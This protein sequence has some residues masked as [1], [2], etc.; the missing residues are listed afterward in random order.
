MP[1]LRESL[2]AINHD[3]TDLDAKWDKAV[4]HDTI[5]EPRKASHTVSSETCLGFV[6]KTPNS[7][8]SLCRILASCPM[9]LAM[10]HPGIVALSDP[11]YA[12]MY[13]L[14]SVAPTP[15]TS[16]DTYITA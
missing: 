9:H 14:P 12:G 10:L 15:D 6:C 1:S 16:A 4:L 7:A 2:Q 8:N 3:K 5:G 13:S 11:A